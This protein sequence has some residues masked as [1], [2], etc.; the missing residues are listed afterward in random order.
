MTELNS[1]RRFGIVI[2]IREQCIAEYRQLHDGEGVRD[3]LRLAKMRNFSICLHQMPDGGL[4]EFGYYE[5]V[6]G[7]YA[8]DMAALAAHP[9]NIEWLNSCDSMQIPLPG[10][11]GWSEMESIFFNA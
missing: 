6:G 7:D 8:A 11:N 1:V 5:Y 2:G 10:T 3:L 4:Y 9:R